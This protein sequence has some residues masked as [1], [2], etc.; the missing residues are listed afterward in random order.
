MTEGV[1]VTSQPVNGAEGRRGC[2]RCDFPITAPTQFPWK[3]IVR[4]DGG[5][6]FGMIWD[7]ST[8]GCA[9]DATEK[10]TTVVEMAHKLRA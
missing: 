4:G 3:M 5:Y 9:T 6:D 8:H 10:I 7:G 2:E 1:R